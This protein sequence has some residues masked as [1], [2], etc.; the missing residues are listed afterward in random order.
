MESAFGAAFGILMAGALFAGGYATL[1]QPVENLKRFPFP[2]VGGIVRTILSA[3]GEATT[4]KF[5]R[6]AAVHMMICGVL[7][8][9][10]AAGAL[11]RQ[12]TLL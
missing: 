2:V 7:T 4:F 3:F 1:L 12:L 9:L 11:F 8:I 6:F 10:A 5:V